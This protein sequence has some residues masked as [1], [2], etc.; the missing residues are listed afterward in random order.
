MRDNPIQFA[1]VRED[2]AVERSILDR[3]DA[4]AKAPRLSVRVRLATSPLPPIAISS[5]Q[6]PREVSQRRCCW[7]RMGPATERALVHCALPE[8]DP[9]RLGG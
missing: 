6:R 1:V 9:Q 3:L 2:S 7:L 4:R 8:L 5:V